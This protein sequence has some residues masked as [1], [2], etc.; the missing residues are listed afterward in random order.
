MG[1]LYDPRILK[2]PPVEKRPSQVVNNYFWGT[3][4]DNRFMGAVSGHFGPLSQRTLTFTI[5]YLF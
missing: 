3:V 2:R 1:R 4:F 5:I